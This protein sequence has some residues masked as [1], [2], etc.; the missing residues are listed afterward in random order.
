MKE[1]LGASLCMAWMYTDWKIGSLHNFQNLYYAHIFGERKCLLCVFCKLSSLDLCEIT[2][3]SFQSPK[4]TWLPIICDLRFWNIGI[5]PISMAIY[6]DVLSIL[7]CRISNI[8]FTW[9]ATWLD[10]LSG[11]H[12]MLKNIQYDYQYLTLVSLMIYVL[13]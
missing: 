3:Y 9:N 7:C 1:R 5:C 11:L 13:N 2:K 12:I 10:K 6:F 4:H 8:E